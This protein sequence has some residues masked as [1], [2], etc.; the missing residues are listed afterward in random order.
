MTTDRLRFAVVG[1]GMFARSQHVPNLAKSA[2]AMLHTVCDA[3][4][5]AL[6]ACKP[7]NPVKISSDWKAALRDPEVQAVCLAATEKLR[8]PVIELAAELG[9]PV[10]VEKPIAKEL[11]EM[12]A[13]QKIVNQSKI[14]F[15]VGHNRRSSPALFEAHR[16]FRSHLQ[17]RNANPWRWS[18]EGPEQKTLPDDGVPAISIR[19]NDDWWSWKNWVFDKTQAP[20]GALLFEMTHFTDVANWFIGAQPVEVF[21][22]ETGMLTHSLIIRYDNGA[23]ATL[24]SSANGT[25]GYP[26][27][28]YECMG[29]GAIVIVDHLLEVR[30]AGV[31]DVPHRITFPLIGDRHPHVGVELGL[32]GW[33]AKKR[34]AAEEAVKSG[35]LLMQFTAEPDRGH[36]RQL[37]RF[38]DQIRGAGP[39]VCPVDAAVLA[40][41]IA[42]AAIKSVHERRIVKLEE[43]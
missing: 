19:I 40:T 13:I 33:L 39:E 25:F 23:L 11:D 7:F 1:C 4:P 38:V 5:N 24:A 3:D 18:R 28:Q 6:D 27:E 29:N 21:A 9:K 36:A 15:C 12:Y 42:F 10:Y 43:I 17:T 35:D 26:K 30:T 2:K 37:D 32:S 20:Y 16:I 41:R 22:M 31:P 34:A 14:P 8:Q